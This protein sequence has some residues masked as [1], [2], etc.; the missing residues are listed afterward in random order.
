MLFS[1]TSKS[2]LSTNKFQLRVCNSSFS[3]G[4]SIDAVGS[5]GTIAC[6]TKE[7]DYIVGRCEEWLRQ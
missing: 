6:K 1:Y 4:F 3:D 2:F 7:F 5:S